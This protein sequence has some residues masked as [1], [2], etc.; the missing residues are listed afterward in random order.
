MEKNKRTGRIS[1][2]LKKEVYEELREIAEQQGIGMST[3]AMQMIT[4]NVKLYKQMYEMMSDPVKLG[5]L[6][7]A[8]GVMDTKDDQ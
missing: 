4:Q 6:S 5:E 8:M 2:Q 7:K 1:V 3:V